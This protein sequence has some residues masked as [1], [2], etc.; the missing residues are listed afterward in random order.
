M[1]SIAGVLP[2]LASTN[3]I[4]ARG[5]AVASHRALVTLFSVSDDDT[6]KMD[7]DERYAME[8][9]AA[10]LA[11]VEAA[12]T[13]Y[14]NAQTSSFDICSLAGISAP[15]GFWDP[16]ALS[17]GR[18]EGTLRFWREVEV[19]HSRVAM[20]AAVGFPVAEQFHPLFGGQID[21]P[22]YLAFQ[23]TPLQTF[24]PVVLFVLS[25]FELYSVF[26][27]DR[28]YDLFY[29]E[30]GGFWSIRSEHEPGDMGFDPLG[31]MP[32]DTAERMVM[33]TKELNHGRA[34]MMGI[35][36]MVAQE[37]VTGDKLF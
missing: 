9:T 26:T 22:S 3:A 2:S 31:L 8:A 23:Q 1:L 17:N 33:E 30:G 35:A 13:A 5:A 29:S 6:S 12:E 28:P 27:F 37:L 14:T 15:L 11:A 19:K 21:V 25:V 7:D 32:M 20:L 36:G 4:A 16:S 18:R 10:A 24:W 34:A